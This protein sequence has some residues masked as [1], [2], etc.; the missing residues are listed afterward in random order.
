MHVRRAYVHAH[1]RKIQYCQHE[2]MSID[3]V[4]ECINARV[5]MTMIHTNKLSYE[6]WVKFFSGERSQNN[7]VVNVYTSWGR[8]THS[9]AKR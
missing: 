8:N 6:E 5:I 7:H 2:L 4:F 3:H 9:N 1:A